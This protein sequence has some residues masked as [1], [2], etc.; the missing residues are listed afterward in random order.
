MEAKLAKWV[1]AKRARDFATADKL[2]D[3]L[4]KAGVDAE[5]AAARPGTDAAAA[6]SPA[7]ASTEVA[8][9]EELT[10]LGLHLARRVESSIL[11]PN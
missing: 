5:A 10:P 1:A 9:T 8:E 6:A 4:R 7:A 3:E 2:R 11:C